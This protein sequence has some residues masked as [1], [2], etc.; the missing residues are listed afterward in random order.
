M[1]KLSVKSRRCTMA[2]IENILT[3]QQLTE[4]AEDILKRLEDENLPLDEAKKLYDEGIATLKEMDE[5]LKA[6]SE[7]VSD[8]VVN[9]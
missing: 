2:K 1:V 5:R 4:K 6:L 3:Y 9:E 8:E 7:E